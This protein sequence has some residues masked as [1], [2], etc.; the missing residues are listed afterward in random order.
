MAFVSEAVSRMMLWYL[1]VTMTVRSRGCDLFNRAH[2]RVLK[3]VKL[4]IPFFFIRSALT[5]V[6]VTSE[7]SRGRRKV[8]SALRMEVISGSAEIVTRPPFPVC[9]SEWLAVVDIIAGDFCFI[10]QMMRSTIDQLMRD[11]ID[12]ILFRCVVEEVCSSMPKVRL[13]RYWLKA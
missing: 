3:A 13:T 2:K 9:D 12:G 10:G 5:V 8:V 7:H 11:I 1:D 4:F 6:R